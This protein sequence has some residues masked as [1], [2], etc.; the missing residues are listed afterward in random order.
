MTLRALYVDF[1]SYFA[2][3]EQQLRPELRNRPV[4][5]LPVAVETTCCIAASHEARRSGVT[6]GTPVRDA[7]RLC[8]AIHFIEA[9]PRLYIDFH[10]RLVE[11]VESCAHVER[12][13]SIDEMY[14]ELTGVL[15]KRERAQA[16]ALDIKQA[17]MEKVGTEL[18]CSIGIGPNVFLAKTASDLE[19]P[20]GL[21]VIE[22]QDLPGRLS[23]LGLRDL[24]GIG[25][26]MEQRLHAA[27]IRSVARLCAA[28]K[29]ELRNVWG[30]IEGEHMHSRLRGDWIA[31]LPTERSSVGHSHVLPPALRSHRAV[32]S[33][34]HRL[35]QKAAMRLRSYGMVASALQVRVRMSNGANWEKKARLDS[36]QD[37]LQ[38]IA[39]LDLLWQGYPAASRIR[40]LAAGIT[41]LELDT[42]LHQ[43]CSLFDDLESRN[44]LNAAVDRLNMRYGMNTVYFGGAHMALMAAPMR[45]AFNHIP[46]LQIEAEK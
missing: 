5:V 12:V 44:R 13:L 23:G 33:V 14:C 16:L 21:T 46:D 1:N 31:E 18:R 36:T 20:D 32:H 27:G 26:E 42:Q 35:L 6:T 28:S 43:S 9:R 30:G 2:S 45:I 3:V 22:K 25:R 29:A 38:L 24:C 7:K 4:A 41:L 39:A 37:T 10:H 8:P 19:K 34:L 40:P 15:T 17:I 11:A